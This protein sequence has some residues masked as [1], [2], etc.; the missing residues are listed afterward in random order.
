[1][2]EQTIRY[3][4]E[5]G[6]V[7]IDSEIREVL[8][9]KNKKALLKLREIQV[10]KVEDEDVSV[11][12]LPNETCQ[13]ISR[14]NER[15]IVRIGEEVREFLGID[16]RKAMLKIG[17]IEVAR[18]NDEAKANINSISMPASIPVFYA[19]AAASWGRLKDVLLRTHADIEY[20]PRGT[21][22][23]KIIGSGIL[24]LMAAAVLLS[25]NGALEALAAGS[26]TEWA[27]LIVALAYGSIIMVFSLPDRKETVRSQLEKAAE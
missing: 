12:D 13:T 1:M 18:F 8:G 17:D 10:V 23:M 7:T 24:I 16:G 19:R 22:S 4:N 15:G 26:K 20:P 3:M 14:I 9:L 11:D 6:S 5:R 25:Q 27:G 2:S 21:T